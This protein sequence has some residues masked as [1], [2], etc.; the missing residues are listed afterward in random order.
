MTF[1][2]TILG[3]SSALP[4]ADRYPTAQVLNVSERFFLIDCGEG[5]QMQLRRNRFSFGK[6]RHV[7]ISHL[8]GDHYFGL[9]GFI[10]SR[11]LLGITSDLHIYSAS[12]LIELLKPQLSYIRSEMGFKVVFH[13][14]NLKVPD[15]IYSDKKCEVF[16]FPLK[17]SIP[18]CGFLFRE[19]QNLPNMIKDKITELKIP[20]REIKAIKEGAGYTAADGTR[21]SHEQL[22]RP[23]AP[24]RSYAFCTDTLP[25]Q[26]A[27]DF[28]RPVSLL[29][30]EATFQ[31]DMEEWA[32]KTYHSTARQ[33]AEFATDAKADRL[34]IG[35]FSNRY[36]DVGNFLKEA[37]DIFPET[38]LA[39]DGMKYTVKTGR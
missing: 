23:A 13:P 38:E 33:A 32:A 28:I 11:N 17:H 14:L 19:K 21:Y 15:L 3:S 25:C 35:H 31:S 9:I 5:T 8:H 6:I 20:I 27:A 30:H 24:P 26:A 16:S 10:S 39:E 4:T 7:F 29:Y 2:L 22:T 1:E 18:V 37:R 12:D 36:D 34:I